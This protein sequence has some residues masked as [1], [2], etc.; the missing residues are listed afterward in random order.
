MKRTHWASANFRSKSTAAST[1][2]G[3]GV[4]KRALGGI[5]TAVA[6]MV[7]VIVLVVIVVSSPPLLKD[8]VSHHHNHQNQPSTDDSESGSG[9]DRVLPQ[10]EK[11]LDTTKPPPPQKGA[12]GGAEKTQDEW[13]LTSEGT[14]FVDGLIVS[15]IADR[16]DRTRTALLES[17]FAHADA[18]GLAPVRACFVSLIR[19]SEDGV[20]KLH[21]LLANVRQQMPKMAGR[22]PFVAFHESIASS[23]DIAKRLLSLEMDFLEGHDPHDGGVWSHQ[24]EAQRSG[25]ETASPHVG[26]DDDNVH[27]HEATTLTHKLVDRVSHDDAAA[28]RFLLRKFV[29]PKSITHPDPILRTDSWQRLPAASGVTSGVELVPLP[30]SDFGEIPSQVKKPKSQWPYPSNS[31][32][33]VGYRHMCRFF[34]IRIFFTP[35]FQQGAFDYYLRLDTDSY[36]LG[37]PLAPSTPSH[38]QLVDDPQ[39]GSG[40]GELTKP[41]DLHRGNNNNAQ[42]QHQQGQPPPSLEEQDLFVAMRRR[43][44]EYGFS[45][46]HPQT[47]RQFMTGLYETYDHFQQEENADKY[48]GGQHAAVERG[49]GTIGRSTSSPL[50]R[51]LSELPFP[52]QDGVHYWDNFEI[53]DLS[54]FR[55]QD[56]VHYWDNFEIVDLSM[57][58]PLR[59]FDVLVKEHD[60]THKQDAAK[61]AAGNGDDGTS[62]EWVLPQMLGDLGVGRIPRDW[63]IHDFDVLPRSAIAGE[64]VSASEESLLVKEVLQR[65]RDA[66]GDNANTTFTK[67]LL[68]P[69][70]RGATATTTEGSSP[71]EIMTHILL[72]AARRKE[73]ASSWVLRAQSTLRRRY[74]TQVARPHN[75]RLR[76]M[77]AWFDRLEEEGGFYYHRWGDAEVRTLTMSMFVDAKNIAWVSSLPYQHYFNFICPAA[78]TSVGNGGGTSAPSKWNALWKQTRDACEAEARKGGGEGK[79]QR[80]TARMMPAEMSHYNHAFDVARNRDGGG[81]WPTL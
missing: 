37:P 5:A 73:W 45:M 30:A 6:F 47:I 70:H 76:R 60:A 75:E 23:G 79:K 35:F 39:S 33:G 78:S 55:P 4:K 25:V 24:R 46:M 59:A 2:V 11:M 40:T 1:T 22:Y 53:V 54:M 63:H 31:Y 64:A 65:L 77:Q 42:G 28:W 19:H 69:P 32:W 14:S 17:R 27:A 52:R 72:Q 44:A 21:R 20:K 15:V 29:F 18:H 51:P 13:T 16:R 57:F 38:F 26:G 56:G 36:I 3:G 80:G 62:K 61:I 7:V 50:H 10:R 9:A 58:R 34:A 12:T 49:R 66:L 48:S 68:T 43:Q 71:V 74:D 41:D 8:A 67:T 81:R